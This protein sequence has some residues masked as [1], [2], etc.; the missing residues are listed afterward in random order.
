VGMYYLVVQE[1]LSYIYITDNAVF[2]DYDFFN[3]VLIAKAFSKNI[4]VFGEISEELLVKISEAKISKLQVYNQIDRNNKYEALDYLDLNH[5]VIVTVMG[6]ITEINDYVSSRAINYN[7]KPIL[8]WSIMSSKNVNL[9]V[10]ENESSVSEHIPADTSAWIS[11]LVKSYGEKY[12]LDSLAKAKENSSILI[13]EVILDEYVYCDPLGKVSK[14]PLIAF[15]KQESVIQLGGVLAIA[16]HI[17]GLGCSTFLISESDQT[18]RGLIEKSLSL[19]NNLNYRFSTINKNIIKTRYVDK[20]SKTRVFETYVMESNEEDLFYDFLKNQVNEIKEKYT[21][22]IVMDYGHSLITGKT[23]EFLLG[24]GLPLSVNTQSNAGN[25]GINSIR[26]YL[27]A[28]K[29][30]LNGSELN[31]ENFGLSGDLN[32]QVVDLSKVINC[33]ESYVTHGANGIVAWGRHSGVVRAPAF[34]PIIVDRVGAGDAALAAISTLRNSKVEVDISL[35]YG[36]I[37]GAMVISSLGNQV[38]LSKDKLLDQANRVF[39]RLN[40][41]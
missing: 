14:E 1:P 30:F 20:L 10:S 34:T 13:G 17:A 19:Y 18:H 26:K 8:N 40:N 7:V 31:R 22:I 16:K 3:A 35:F 24:C 25:F 39:K 37:A 6:S 15:L 4:T 32:R 5:K 9:I 21:N 33:E 12:I 41:Y 38:S 11:S 27:G 2:E 23:I 29:I 28:S 36:N